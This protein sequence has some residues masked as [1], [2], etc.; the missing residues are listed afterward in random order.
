MEPG[1]DFE[2]REISQA[3]QN[4]TAVTTPTDLEAT[5]VKIPGCSATLIR[6]TWVITAGHCVG[7]T[8][9]IGQEYV[10]NGL[11]GD[12]TAVVATTWDGRSATGINI[13]L[14][15]DRAL[16]AALVELGTPLEIAEPLEMFSGWDS[17]VLGANADLYGFGPTAISNPVNGTCSANSTC[18]NSQNCV[19]SLSPTNQPQFSCWTYPGSKPFPT[20]NLSTAVSTINSITHD[21]NGAAYKGKY[22]S[23]TPWALPGDSG[24]PSFIGNDKLVGVNGGFPHKTY[25]K[26]FRDWVEGTIE[27]TTSD[28]FGAS[29]IHGYF[30][31]QNELAD[32]GDFNND[33]RA[34]LITFVRGSQ[35][36]AAAGD[37]YV[38]LANANGT[39]QSGQKWHENFA[40]G[41]SGSIYPKTGDFDGDGDDDI[42][43]F[44]HRDGNA[45]VALSNGVN[46]FGS[47]AL[48]KTSFSFP[49]EVP[50]V[51]DFDGDSIDDI[52]TFVQQ[53]GWQDVWVSLSCS[54]PV[55]PS[56][57]AGCAS[58]SNAF[59]DRQLWTT[60]FSQAGEAPRV[61][62][63]NGD[64]MDDIVTFSGSGDVEV[65]LTQHQACTV[66][67]DCP[68][69]G[70]CFVGL[71]GGTCAASRGMQAGPKVLW[72]TGFAGGGDLPEVGD[73]NGD[74]YDDIANFEMNSTGDVYVAVANASPLD[75]VGN[76]ILGFEPATK[77]RGPF[78]TGYQGV[79]VGDS[80]RDGRDDIFRFVRNTVT[81]SG[82]GDVWV[83]LSSGI[84]QAWNCPDSSYNSADGC[85]CG[86]GEVDPDCSL[87]NQSVN[88]CGAGESCD[89][90]GECEQLPHPPA[91]PL[92]KYEQLGGV[93]FGTTG[94]VWYS[95]TS[96]LT[97]WQASQIAGRTIEVNGVPVSP[98]Q[99]PL[100]PPVDGLYI[101]H[102]SAGSNS[103]ASWSWW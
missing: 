41:P 37:V 64:N 77:W 86:C 25:A 40:N 99:M 70:H 54:Q 76:D 60:S 17:D 33:G 66:N 84:P 23:S 1:E 56:L 39:Y 88:G 102:F 4:G 5:I 7:G 16:D 73:F 51:G 97:G 67:T 12:P 19:D 80:N 29:V 74:G 22:L 72:V 61:G 2:V 81:G 87:S 9:L 11:P 93:G 100:P 32:T 10:S 89:P 68:N 18:T 14:H 3:V 92:A 82:V 38:S 57:P 42:I 95:A 8:T 78:A 101:F 30:S 15:P 31:I 13:Y 27:P 98:G 96:D 59:G 94:E 53:P 43:Y 91:I 58:V 6:P 69:E 103:W 26:V 50:E 71:R 47:A 44:D 49:G 85:D 20:W 21:S 46:G 36:G 79:S 63:F 35:G 83:G 75:A 48:W 90:H 28:K 62:D 52:I 34:D 45:F 24:G 65:A 55:T